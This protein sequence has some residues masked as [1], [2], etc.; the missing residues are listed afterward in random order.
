MDYSTGSYN[1]ENIEET[2]G[3]YIYEDKD[4]D[5]NLFLY[6]KSDKKNLQVA[7][8]VSYD[9]NLKNCDYLAVIFK[10]GADYLGQNSLENIQSLIQEENMQNILE[11]TYPEL[12][13]QIPNFTQEQYDN[14][15]SFS[16]QQ[17]KL[18][19]ELDVE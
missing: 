10:R 16:K 9:E 13:R 3:A 12:S 18:A 5:I 17:L 14:Y 19:A 8:P 15:F 1:E 2:H 11:K 4:K 6:I 7:L